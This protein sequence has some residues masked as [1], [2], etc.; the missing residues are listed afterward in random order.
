MKNIEA[1]LVSFA[2]L[3]SLILAQGADL[4]P[5]TRLK[6]TVYL[7]AGRLRCD[8]V[9]EMLADVAVTND[10]EITGPRANDKCNYTISLLFLYIP[11]TMTCTD[12]A[13]LGKCLD[14]DRDLT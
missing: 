5:I 10:A 11:P 8:C 9:Q 12:T 6:D 13:S 1:P 4:L 3:E 2:G 14:R 7:V